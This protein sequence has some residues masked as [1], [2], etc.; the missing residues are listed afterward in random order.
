MWA[1]VLW[2]IVLSILMCACI[3]LETKVAD[4]IASE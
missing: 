3:C 1:L 2:T 4:M